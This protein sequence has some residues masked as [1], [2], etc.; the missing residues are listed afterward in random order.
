MKRHLIFGMLILGLCLSSGNPAAL[1]DSYTISASSSVDTP[2][3]QVTVDG[4]QHTVSNIAKTAPGRTLSVSVSAPDETDYTIQLRN[5]KRQVTTDRDGTGDSQVTFDFTGYKPGS[6]ML[7]LYKNGEYKDILPVVVSGY[8]ISVDAPSTTTPESIVTVDVSATKSA[9]VESPN[10]VYVVFTTGE[11]TKRVQAE[12]RSSTSYQAS[13]S[14]ENIPTGD[15]RLYAYVQGS[16]TAFKEGKKE[17]LGISHSSSLTVRKQ[18]TTTST[19]SDSNSNTGQTGSSSKS[20]DTTT[21]TRPTTTQTI[22]NLT[23]TTSQQSPTS[24]QTTTSTTTTQTSTPTK[25]TTS[26][27]LI[28]PNKTTTNTST[29]TNSQEGIPGFEISTAIMAL[30]AIGILLSRR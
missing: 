21:T 30:V 28:T 23:T 17:I 3:R 10:A 22:E 16:N 9:D 29:T 7:L 5:R 19:T 24:T 26:S 18:G 4:T 1:T 27:S 6:Y 14:L 11:K 8:D 12:K 13:I 2:T 20:T 15:H 25:K